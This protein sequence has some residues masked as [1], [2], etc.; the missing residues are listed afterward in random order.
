MQC[1]RPDFT[2]VHPVSRV[3][4]YTDAGERDAAGGTPLQ[5][6]TTGGGDRPG[7]ASWRRDLRWNA[8]GKVQVLPGDKKTTLEKN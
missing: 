8:Y 3:H 4:T 6:A 5:Y 7:S 1:F 2:Y